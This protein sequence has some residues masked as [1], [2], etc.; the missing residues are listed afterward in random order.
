MSA[1]NEI[2]NLLARLAQLA[3]AGEVDA[4][5]GLMTDDVV[6]AMP[7]SPHVGLAASARTGH[8]EIAAGARDRIAAGLQGPGTHTMH[9]VTTTAITMTSDVDATADSAFVFWTNTATEP[10]ATSVGRYR[11]TFRR[12]DGEWKLARREIRF[13]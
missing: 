1:E 8:D 9:T 6:W 11:D 3:D 4:Y 2:R 13:D 5:V 12:V 10:T 7:A